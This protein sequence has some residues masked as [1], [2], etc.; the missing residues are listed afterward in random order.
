MV[1]EPLCDV[2][3][4]LE[5]SYVYSGSFNEI[6]WSVVDIPAVGYPIPDRAQHTIFGVILAGHCFG[7][8]RLYFLSEPLCDVGTPS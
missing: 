7:Q 8:F 3:N 5:L 2:G 1:R 6:K 4:P